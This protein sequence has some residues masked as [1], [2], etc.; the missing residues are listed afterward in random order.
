[1]AACWPA[2]NVES[3]RLILATITSKTSSKVGK[4]NAYGDRGLP[5]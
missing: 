5:S 3:G 2:E 4:S 1:M